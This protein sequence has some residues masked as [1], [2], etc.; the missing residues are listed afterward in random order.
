[1]KV[2][3]LRH[4]EFHYVDQWLPLIKPHP[5]NIITHFKYC[6]S[7]SVFPWLIYC[8]LFLRNALK[9]KLGWRNFSKAWIIRQLAGLWISNWS[10]VEMVSESG[11]Q[12][13]NDV[14]CTEEKFQLCC[15][16]FA[17]PPSGGKTRGTRKTGCVYSDNPGEQI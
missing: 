14:G 11:K 13:L 15:G 5:F 6:F 1:M 4:C 12:E 8:L 16:L 10:S 17:I 7:V 2:T 9:R 3:L